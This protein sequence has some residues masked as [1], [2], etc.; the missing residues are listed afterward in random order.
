MEKAGIKIVVVVGVLAA[1]VAVMGLAQ[2][3]QDQQPEMTVYK[4]PG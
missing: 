2:Q 3:A 1:G 4:D